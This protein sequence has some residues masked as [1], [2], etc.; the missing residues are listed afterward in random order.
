MHAAS[1]RRALIAVCLSLTSI[2]TLVVASPAT[3]QGD[4]GTAAPEDAA[5]S[6]ASATWYEAAATVRE[7]VRA[8]PQ[9]PNPGASA[10]LAQHARFAEAKLEWLERFPFE[11]GLRQWDCT[12]SEVVHVRVASTADQPA[13]V[14]TAMVVDCE[15]GGRV[16]GLGVILSPRPEATEAPEAG[17]GPVA[18]CAEMRQGRQCLTVYP[19]SENDTS[20]DYTWNGSTST[21]GRLRI[22]A[23]PP[24][25]PTTCG[26]GTHVASGPLFELKPGQSTAL[27]TSPAPGV[28]RSA[29]WEETNASGGASVRSVLCVLE[30]AQPK[31]WTPIS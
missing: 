12:L 2:A 25:W 9:P 19:V 1:R 15:E 4:L 21:V 6:A 11:A 17:G 5:A 18:T 23:L 20:V 8:N 22:E 10:P 31:T 7:F 24:I 29:I 26:V 28:V 16:P 14:D 13:R 30:P 3:A 27:F